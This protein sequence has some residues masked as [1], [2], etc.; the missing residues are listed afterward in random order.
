MTDLDHSLEES[1]SKV[2]GADIQRSLR[3]QAQ[4]ADGRDQA[5]VQ[6]LADEIAR[7]QQGV[8]LWALAIGGIL[9]GILIWRLSV[10]DESS[11]LTDVASGR[12]ILMLI[13]VM[14]TVVFGGILLSRALA[15]GTDSAD[16][17]NR[18]RMGREVFLVFSGICATVVGFYFGSADRD[19]GAQAAVGISSSLAPDGVIAALVSGGAPPYKVSLVDGEANLPLTPD[20]S[21]P[22]R[23]TLAPIAAPGQCPAGGRFEVGGANGAGYPTVPLA[24]SQSQLAAQGWQVACGGEG[25]PDAAAPASADEPVGDEAASDDP[26]TDTPPDAALPDGSP[27]EL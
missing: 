12:P 16:F 8:G 6:K 3:S 18:F 5:Q 14:T 10:A 17:E 22:A 27:G 21:D 13:I 20:E 9:V 2:K 24:F 7:S 26:V 19:G 15:P 23:F 1:I 11:P 25:E 4:T